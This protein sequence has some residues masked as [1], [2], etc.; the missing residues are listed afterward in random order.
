M[1]RGPIPKWHKDRLVLIGDAAH[2]M[3]TCKS[4]VCFPHV[5]RVS[6]PPPNIHPSVSP[7]KVS[8]LLIL[9]VTNP[10]SRVKVADRPSRT[11]PPS[12][13]CSTRFVIRGLSRTDCSCLSRSAGTEARRCRF[14]P[15][16]TRRRR[17]A[18]AMPPPRTFPVARGSILLTTST[19]TSFRLM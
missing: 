16:R 14:F 15:T 7:E 2:P 8:S 9:V 4:E 12:V 10:Q 5:H 17:R 6:F 11:A 13:F 19:T 1:A 3:L 18:F